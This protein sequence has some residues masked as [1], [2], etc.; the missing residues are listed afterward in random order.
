M[1]YSHFNLNSIRSKHGITLKS[2]SGKPRKKQFYR[3]LGLFGFLFFNR[4]I[5]SNQAYDIYTSEFAILLLKDFFQIIAYQWED[6]T[7][8]PVKSREKLAFNSLHPR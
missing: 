1:K 5:I 6:M 8:L 7:E 2:L 4:F 3:L